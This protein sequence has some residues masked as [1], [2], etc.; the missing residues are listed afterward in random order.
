MRRRPFHQLRGSRRQPSATL[1]RRR[2]QTAQCARR[3]RQTAARSRRG[4][5]RGHRSR[6]LSRLTTCQPFAV[7]L[8]R[9]ELNYWASLFVILE[10]VLPLN[11]GHPCD[12]VVGPPLVL[13]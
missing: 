6:R 11:W 3:T 5:P 1:T 2:T 9:G 13:V 4:P 12:R 7:F 8:F 10:S